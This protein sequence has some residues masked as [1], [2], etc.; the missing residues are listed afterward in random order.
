[1]IGELTKAGE[2]IAWNPQLMSAVERGRQSP[3]MRCFLSQRVFIGRK[4]IHPASLVQSNVADLQEAS[5]VLRV[6]LGP[7]LEHCG[8]AIQIATSSCGVGYRDSR[9][10]VRGFSIA[11]LSQGDGLFK[12]PVLAQQQRSNHLAVRPHSVLR[13]RVLKKG[14]EISSLLLVVFRQGRERFRY[15]YRSLEDITKD[16]AGLHA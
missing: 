6:M 13:L 7:F 2:P 15:L 4:R 5:N 9:L 8:G 3:L 14:Q 11:L 1:M 12:S 16:F 10:P